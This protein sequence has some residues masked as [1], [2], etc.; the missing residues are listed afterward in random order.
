M[1][2]NNHSLPVILAAKTAKAFEFLTSDDLFA[3]PAAR[4]I[5]LLGLGLC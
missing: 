3:K 1:E 4:N 2:Q 5:G